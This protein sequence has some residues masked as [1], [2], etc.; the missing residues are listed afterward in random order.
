MS[1]IGN[2]PINIPTGIEITV[3]PNHVVKVKSSKGTLEQKL[4]LT[5]IQIDIAADKVTL[6]PTNQE[7]QTRALHGLY[8]MLISNM[9][10]GLTKGFEKKLELVGVGYRASVQGNLLD[11]SIGFSHNIVFEFPDSIKMTTSQEKGAN[12]MIAIQGVDKQLVGAIA[13]KIRSLR[14][15]EPYQ[16]KG[17]KYVGEYIRRKAGK[18]ASKGA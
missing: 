7:N 9:I 6:K 17:I 8:R 5:N 11:L 16:G 13:A 12:P 3:S 14:K 2:Q 18:S 4:D 15:P 10:E 1:R